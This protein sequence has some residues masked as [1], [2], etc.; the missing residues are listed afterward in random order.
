MHGK[1]SG[2]ASVRNSRILTRYVWSSKKGP[3]PRACRPPFE[4]SMVS[5]EGDICIHNHGPRQAHVVITREEIGGLMS[6]LLAVDSLP[7]GRT[8]LTDWAKEHRKTL[9]VHYASELSRRMAQKKLDHLMEIEKA[10]VWSPFELSKLS[11][12]YS[13]TAS[14]LSRYCLK[15]TISFVLDDFNCAS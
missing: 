13:L 15:F 14:N 12:E 1:L 9:G 2:N 5:A 11:P 10:A 8:K 7:A 3:V 4:L 6:G